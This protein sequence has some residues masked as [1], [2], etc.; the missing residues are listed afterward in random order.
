MHHNSCVP[1]GDIAAPCVTWEEM[2]AHSRIDSEAEKTL[3]EDYLEGADQLIRL[4][5]TMALNEQEY[6]VR[7]PDFAVN[8]KT[9]ERN[10]PMKLP[11]YPLVVEGEISVHYTD[12]AGVESE[13][14]DF[15]IDY[16]T[17]PGY[18]VPLPG[19][20]WPEVQKG[21]I[22]PVWI[23]FPAGF[24]TVPK[25]YKQLIRLCAALWY[26]LRIPVTFE[27]IRKMPTPAGFD[28]MIFNLRVE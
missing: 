15:Q 6:T 1:T 24:E 7:Y 17:K 14:D 25:V 3:M 20:F 4:H 18:I 23:V 9:G 28:S 21:R 26:E 27:D 12:T 11:I 19:Q 8:E 10:G 2:K 5:L 16:W 22:N 13:V